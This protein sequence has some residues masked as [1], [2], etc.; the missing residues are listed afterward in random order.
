MTT[1]AA[2]LDRLI[3]VQLDDVGIVQLVVPLDRLAFEDA[4]PPDPGEF[5]R[6][7]EVLVDLPGQ[8]EN[9]AADGHGERP[10]PIDRLAR[11]FRVDP[12]H[13]Q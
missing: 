2:T 1:P 12:K 3:D 8:I 7:L 6:V 9:R 13:S 5:Q 10:R 11:D 4:R